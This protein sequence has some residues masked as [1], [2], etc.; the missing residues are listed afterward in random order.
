[1]YVQKRVSVTTGSI[2]DR[3]SHIF[4]STHSLSTTPLIA[5]ARHRSV[6]NPLICLKMT[7][8]PETCAFTGIPAWIACALHLLHLDVPAVP[9]SCQRRQISFSLP[10]FSVSLGMLIILGLSTNHPF[11]S[12]PTAEL[13]P[14][15]D[16]SSFTSLS[17]ALSLPP[18]NPL[19][20]IRT[21]TS[22]GYGKLLQLLITG[23]F[24]APADSVNIF[25]AYKMSCLPL[26]PPPPSPISCIRA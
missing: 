20:P 14:N 10:H 8:A 5:R 17:A 15:S 1:M 9:Q 19:T 16:Y 12:H 22:T 25:D 2:R 18:L 21:L 24:T 3:I 11:P 4:P 23:R 26:Y 13:L 6:R 7:I